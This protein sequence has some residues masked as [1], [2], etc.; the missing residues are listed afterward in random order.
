MGVY[1]LRE[2]LT[3]LSVANPVLGV[4]AVTDLV[5]RRPGS[6]SP[7]VRSMALAG[8]YASIAGVLATPPRDM[9]TLEALLRGIAPRATLSDLRPR[10]RAR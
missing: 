3:G 5:L 1:A 10:R 6:M 9:A 2:T 4:P 7:T 8:E